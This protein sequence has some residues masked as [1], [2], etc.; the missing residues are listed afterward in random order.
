MSIK[1]KQDFRKVN[2]KIRHRENF[3][4]YPRVPNFDKR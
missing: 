1:T 3:K 2:R 4:K